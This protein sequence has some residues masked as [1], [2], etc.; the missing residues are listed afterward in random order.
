[1]YSAISISQFCCVIDRARHAGS[2]GRVHLRDDSGFE[3]A[4][5]PSVINAKLVPVDGYP[6]RSMQDFNRW[7]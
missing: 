3:H 7:L 4:Y 2:T 6:M 1:M 5:Y